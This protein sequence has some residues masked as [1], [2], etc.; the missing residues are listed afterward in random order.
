MRWESGESG[1][2]CADQGGN[3]GNRDG[4]ALNQGRNAGNRDGNAGNQGE[5]ARNIIETEKTK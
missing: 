5:N 2:E 3:T 1:W 4:Y